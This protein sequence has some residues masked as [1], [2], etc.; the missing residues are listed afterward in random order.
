MIVW[1]MDAAILYLLCITVP[2]LGLGCLVYYLF[3][4]GVAVKQRP[5]KHKGMQERLA[6]L[7]REQKEN[8]KHYQQKEVDKLNQKWEDS[9]H[10]R[11][12]PLQLTGLAAVLLIAGWGLSYV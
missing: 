12:S 6:R 11:L 5:A 1:L 7:A 10:E 3:T 9:A 2:L 4:V 8:D